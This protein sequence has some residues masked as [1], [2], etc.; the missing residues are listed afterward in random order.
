MF[1][2]CTAGATD[3]KVLSVRGRVSIHTAYHTVPVNTGESIP[4]SATIELSKDG[5]LLIMSGEGSV[6]ELIT[7]GR[8]S[9]S[10]VF[11]N[12]KTSPTLTRIA[13]YLISNVVVKNNTSSERGAIYR[14][15]NV[16]FVWPPS[17]TIDTAACRVWWKR[18]PDE[19]ML[20]TITV[21][22]DKDSVLV[23]YHVADTVFMLQLSTD[24][25][26]LGQTFRC[27]TIEAD[28]GV[29]T[30]VTSR[31][32]RGVTPEQMRELQVDLDQ[33]SSAFP[34]PNEHLSLNAARAA[35][36]GIVYEEY[37]LYDRALQMYRKAL[38]VEKTPEYQ[39]LYDRCY[40][41][42]EE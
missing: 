41:R 32:I 36:T 12:R 7:P 6:A 9:A 24:M 8:Y 2:C 13:K 40:Q 23:T 37:G 10:R 14:G 27:F 11:D 26:D 25:S 16:R 18:L 5:Y 28:S 34:N 29:S 4:S 42:G 33:V 39:A 22:N 38:L 15:T 21:Y 3:A 30:E 17:T 35:F 19:L 20:Y 31:C 1:Q